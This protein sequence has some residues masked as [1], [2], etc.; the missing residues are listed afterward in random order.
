MTKQ[1]LTE[2]I[3]YIKWLL[4]HKGKGYTT[5]FYENSLQTRL[6]KLEEKKQ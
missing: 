2:E 1:D 3:E 5:A 6:D 4:E